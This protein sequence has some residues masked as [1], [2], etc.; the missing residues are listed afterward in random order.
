MSL[1]VLIHHLTNI[2]PCIT[3][4]VIVLGTLHMFSFHQTC[5][6]LRLKHHFVRNA[7]LFSAPAFVVA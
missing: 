3:G 6:M 7:L 2:S 4:C 1:C 5:C